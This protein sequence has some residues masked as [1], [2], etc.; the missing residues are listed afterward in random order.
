MAEILPVRRSIFL[1]VSVS[2]FTGGLG[3][4]TQENSSG[5][6]KAGKKKSLG[7]IERK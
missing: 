1:G 3:R 4:K 6:I 7:L 2:H 5:G